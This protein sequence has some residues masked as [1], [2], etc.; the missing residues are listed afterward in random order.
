MCCFCSLYDSGFVDG[1]VRKFVFYCANFGVF[2]LVPHSLFVGMFFSSSG[3][4]MSIRVTYFT[5]AVVLLDLV[6]RGAIFNSF[7]LRTVFFM[8]DRTVFISSSIDFFT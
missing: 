1:D 5:S 7:F 2:G 3:F 6:L 4:S 8:K